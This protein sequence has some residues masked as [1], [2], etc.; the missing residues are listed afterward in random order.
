MKS[1][2]CCWEQDGPPACGQ[3]LASHKQ[4]C[5]CE[6]K[7]LSTNNIQGWSDRFDSVFP[8]LSWYTQ[9]FTDGWMCNPQNPNKNGEA[10]E[11]VI[12]QQM[13]NHRNAIK[14]FIA[15]EIQKAEVRVLEEVDK[16]VMSDFPTAFHV[17][18]FTDPEQHHEKCSYRQMTRAVFC[19][20][21]AEKAF[22]ATIDYIKSILF[23][24]NPSTNQS[25]E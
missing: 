5:L 11:L 20:C 4:C 23:L 15:S 21:A 14:S 18:A 7:P 10:T 22:I 2:Y 6:N 16:Q 25:G 17:M 3:D 13:E 19:D 12:A 1:H 8:K 9:G 24:I